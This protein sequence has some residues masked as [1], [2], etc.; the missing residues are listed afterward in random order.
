MSPLD[1]MRV[2]A[3]PNANTFEIEPIYNLIHRYLSDSAI[4]VDPFARD[5][6]MATYTN[7]LNPET[8]AQHHLDAYE[9]LVMLKTTDVHADLVILDPPYGPRQIVDCYNSIGID[10]GTASKVRNRLPTQRMGW[11]PEKDII[12]SMQQQG[13]K[14]ICCGWHSNGMGKDRGY[15]LIEVM[16]VAHGGSRNDTIVT[17]EKK[18]QDDLFR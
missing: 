9:F 8:K 12:A 7:D 3:M 10:T 5:T 4:S 17:V 15:R 6:E 11:K 2:W 1:F 18:I 14:V 16:L 13:D